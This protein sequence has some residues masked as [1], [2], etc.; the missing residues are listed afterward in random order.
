[1]E[2]NQQVK[3]KKPIKRIIPEKIAEVGQWKMVEP[4]DDEVVNEGNKTVHEED[5]AVVDEEHKQEVSVED[6][7]MD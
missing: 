3:Q 4:K 7:K 1:M 6:V 5:K 2:I